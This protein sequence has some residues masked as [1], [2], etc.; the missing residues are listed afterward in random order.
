MTFFFFKVYFKNTVYASP[1]L[2]FKLFCTDWKI[3]LI[4]INDR[5][6]KCAV[7]NK[8]EDRACDC[9]E[10]VPKRYQSIHIDA[11]SICGAVKPTVS[12]CASLISRLIPTRDTRN[13]HR[14]QKQTIKVLSGGLPKARHQLL[15]SHISLLHVA[16]TRTSERITKDLDLRVFIFKHGLPVIKKH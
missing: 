2:H 15:K 9:T 7:N 12:C 3:V 11:I 16:A 5:N 13:L 8:S 1:K 6:V 10:S 4:Y 14:C